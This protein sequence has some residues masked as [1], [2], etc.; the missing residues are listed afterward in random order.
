ML[1]AFYE[2]T[3]LKMKLW[4]KREYEEKVKSRSQT[5]VCTGLVCFIV[6][7]LNLV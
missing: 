2:L 3:A 7:L 6:S 1:G 4:W 5:V